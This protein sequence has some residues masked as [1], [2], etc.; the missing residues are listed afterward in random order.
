MCLQMRNF[1]K[2]YSFE[3]WDLAQSLQRQNTRGIKAPI[4]TNIGNMEELSSSA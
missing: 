1:S 3:I 4:A 2:S